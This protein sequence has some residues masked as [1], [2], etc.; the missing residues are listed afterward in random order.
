MR[1]ECVCA[2]VHMACSLEV[3][4][5][6]V[7]RRYRSYRQLELFQFGYICTE[8]TDYTDYTM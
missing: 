5:T 8:Y 1:G 2:C 3:F 4:L 7:R 6:L